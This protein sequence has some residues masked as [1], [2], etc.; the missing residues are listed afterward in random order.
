MYSKSWSNDY[1]TGDIRYTRCA[2]DN[3]IVSVMHKTNINQ[4]LDYFI[5]HKGAQKS[6]NSIYQ[7]FCA[8]YYKELSRS[9]LTICHNKIKASHYLKPWWC[10]ELAKLWSRLVAKDKELKHPHPCW[11]RRKEHHEFKL[12]YKFFDH[13][14]RRHKRKHLWSKETEL[15]QVNT[16]DPNAF[17]KYLKILE[18]RDSKG[19]S[20][21]VYDNN[22][23]VT[24][25]LNFALQEWVNDEQSQ[26]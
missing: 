18:P 15:E 16:S 5:N 23:E 1:Q 19:P 25:G 11:K 26:L 3:C 8:L 13:D 22:N 10:D 4:I 17:W 6:V 2:P 12:A 24:L 7:Q 9:N 20:F 21:E 14:F